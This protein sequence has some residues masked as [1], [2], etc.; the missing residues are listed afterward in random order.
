MTFFEYAMS[1]S[2]KDR[3][4]RQASAAKAEVTP[5]S[6]NL[7]TQSGTFVGSYGSYETNLIQCQCI[8]FSKR[9]L[10]CKHMYRLA[11]E[12]GEMPLENV[13]TDASQQISPRKHYKTKQ[14]QKA[15]DN[16]LAI[17]ET[18]PDELQMF[19]RDIL[20]CRY[21][22]ELFVCN[23]AVMLDRP[24]ADGLIEDMHDYEKII[25][26]VGKE[27]TIG[28]LMEINFSFPDSLSRTNTA[29][30]DWCIQNAQYVCK[31][32]YPDFGSYVTC[33]DLE[34]ANRKIYSYL[35]EKYFIP[36]VIIF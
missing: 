10:P 32:I 24:L 31:L 15:T 5:V 18:Y 34:I 19:V 36:D 29:R 7:E 2:E 33:G 21:K 6:V 4:N 22:N 8:D 17:I 14:R 3:S 12:L 26:A 1:D 30:F 16:C 13:K 9:K 35:K 20:S 27:T 28:K 11:H 25:Y 23:D